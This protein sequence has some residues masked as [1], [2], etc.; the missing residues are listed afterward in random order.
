MRTEEKGDRV[1]WPEAGAGEFLSTACPVFTFPL[2]NIWC[3][4]VGLFAL[5]PRFPVETLRVSHHGEGAAAGKLRGMG[6]SH[7][8]GERGIFV[9]P[10]GP[11]RRR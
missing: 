5:T 9:V 8:G 10:Q 2:S 1:S 3:C 4:D 7:L 6:L 11:M